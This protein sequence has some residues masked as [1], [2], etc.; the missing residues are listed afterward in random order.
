MTEHASLFSSVAVLAEFHPQAKALRFWRDE[1]QQQLHA[2]VELYDSPLPALEELEADIALVSDTLSEAALPDF[3]AFC[4][5]IEVIF[6][7]SQ[8]S[9]PVSQ[10]EG[11]DWP[12]FRRISA[13]AQYWQ[14]RNPREVNKL[15][16]FMMGIPLYSQLLGSFI[17]RRHGEAEQEII[18]KT[19]TPGAVYIMGVNRFNQL[20]RE[21]IDTAFNEAKLLVS[22][23][24]GT[25]DENAAKIINGMVKSMLFH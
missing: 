13:Y 14:D 3:H 9:G 16:T 17:T 21:D 1:K 22:T 5:D 4:Q 11:V 12:R 23:F 15:L 20:F 19:A 25:R 18:E 7:G 10:L 8:P 2:K 6:H 24:R